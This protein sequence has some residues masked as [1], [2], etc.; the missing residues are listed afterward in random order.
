MVMFFFIGFIGA[1]FYIADEHLSFPSA[2]LD[3]GFFG[4]Q[5]ADSEMIGHSEVNTNSK[6]S[7]FYLCEKGTSGLSGFWDKGVNQ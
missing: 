4:D 7:V 3:Y 1:E 5:T 6:G 2:E